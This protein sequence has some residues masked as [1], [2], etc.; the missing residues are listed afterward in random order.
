MQSVDTLLMKKLYERTRAANLVKQIWR[1]YSPKI[2]PK[3]KVHQRSAKPSRL[4]LDQIEA[5]T[6][7]ITKAKKALGIRSVKIAGQWRWKYPT[8]T[9]EQALKYLGERSTNP[10]S[11][12]YQMRQNE[13]DQLKKDATAI[14]TDYFRQVGY[15]VAAEEM[16]SLL[17]SFHLHSKGHYLSEAKREMNIKRIVLPDNTYWIWSDDLVYDWLQEQ[18][19]D[20]PLSSSEIF[21]RAKEKG[22]DEEVILH[23]RASFGAI[24]QMPGDTPPAT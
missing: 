21:K 6:L 5:S 4:F 22:W 12:L 9:L 8:R 20:G 17:R 14:L 19:V 13:H 18:F 3:G 23:A 16:M 11:L 24:R 2:T 10:D 7:V 1:I 15:K